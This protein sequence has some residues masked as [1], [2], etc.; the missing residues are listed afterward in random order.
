MDITYLTDNTCKDCFNVI[1]LKGSFQSLGVFI[2]N[3]KYVDISSPEGKSFLI[4]YNITQ[5]PTI[6]LSKD[7]N[8]YE[9]IKKVLEQAGTFEE[10]N[11]FVFRKLESLNVKYNEL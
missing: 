1:E 11:K 6:I 3:E 4:K 10:D 2:D 8:D 7:I 9:T 5:V